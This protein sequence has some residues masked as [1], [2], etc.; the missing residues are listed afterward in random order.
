MNVGN[1]LRE[2]LR[3]V[4]RGATGDSTSFLEGAKQEVKDAAKDAARDGAKEAAEKAKCALF[5]QAEGLL[6]RARGRPGRSPVP[7]V[8]L[9]ADVSVLFMT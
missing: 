3:G 7:A 9:W 2:A 5:H 8:S 1:Q 4:G 6:A